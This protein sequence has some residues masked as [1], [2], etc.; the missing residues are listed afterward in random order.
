[1][2]GFASC[3]DKNFIESCGTRQEKTRSISLIERVI[4]RGS[5]NIISD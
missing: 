4:L 2:A 3:W 5:F 1:M